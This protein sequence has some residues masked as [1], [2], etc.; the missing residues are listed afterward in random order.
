VPIIELVVLLLVRVVRLRV[1]VKS[2]FLPEP[3]RLLLYR[4]ADR[5]LGGVDGDPKVAFDDFVDC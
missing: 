3:N 4:F 2:L 1:T 5:E